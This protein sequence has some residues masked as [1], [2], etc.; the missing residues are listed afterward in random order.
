MNQSEKRKQLI[1]VAKMYYYGHMTQQEICEVMQTSRV[2]VSRMLQEAEKLGIVQVQIND[3]YFNREESEQILKDYLGISFVIIVPSSGNND[4][5]KHNIGVAA[6][7]FLNARLTDRMKIGISW[8]TTVSAFVS[9]Y[10]AAKPYPK[11]MI[12][13]LT[14]GTYIQS[15]HMDGRELARILAG[16]LKCGYSS[17]QA[18]TY[19]HSTELKSLL[20]KEPETIRHY[21]L[22]DD[23]DIAFVG[24][25]SSVYKE[26]VI[27]K[28]QYLEEEAAKN[29]Y[30][31]GLCDICGHQI[32]E[33]GFEPDNYFSQRH[34]G[35]SLECLRKTPITVG[36]CS[37]NDRAKSI[38]S[39]VRGGYLNGLIIDEIAAISLLETAENN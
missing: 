36:I 4:D 19:V 27:F 32:D 7:D 9:A 18:P 16:K 23:L 37:G 38:L 17:L 10:H 28:A 20:L 8:G 30:S 5:V 15:M 6:T 24:I 34:I 29:L 1:K 25:G 14:G 3:P 26:S 13:Q 22:M 11:A 2:K 12:V 31:T 35:I 39:A 21:E 33:N